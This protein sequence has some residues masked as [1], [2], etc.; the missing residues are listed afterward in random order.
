[1]NRRFDIVVIGG[2]IVGLAT[3]RALQDGL[4][5]AGI[6]VLE[7]EAAVGSHQTG[8]NSG[9]IHS[10]LYYRPGSLKA[11]LCVRGRE[12]MLD[13]CRDAGIPFRVP[14]KLVV[15][16]REREIPILD[17]LQMNGIA[18]GLEI[19]RLGP[20]GIVEHE[21]HAVGVAALRVA[22]TGVVDFG[23]VARHLAGDLVGAGAEILTGWQ[24]DRIQIGDGGATVGS[25]EG[26]V[27]GRVVVNAAGLHA[28]RVARLSGEEPPV[29]IVPF[30]GEY[31]LLSAEASGLVGGLIYP[32]P[33]PRF[34]F[35]GVHF[36]RGIDDSV[37]VGPNAVLAL[38]REH[39]R[40]TRAQLSGLTEALGFRGFR[41]LARRHAVS[42]LAEMV[43]SKSRVLYA[44]EARRLVPALRSTD[45]RV[46]GSGVRAQAVYPDGALADDFVIAGDGPMLHEL[47][48]PSP[49]ATAAL[50]IG[51][52]LAQMVRD[53][54]GR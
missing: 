54:L 9:V 12:Q 51:D 49:A 39:Y 5:G 40:G 11:Q 38:G 25:G 30:R 6:V 32:V 48:A 52:H 22:A 33:D 19:E 1:M 53:R 35:L 45:L 13:Y 14:G 18:N 4:P 16:T 41:R 37:E 36:T 46:G 24:V 17:D 28:D 50:A 31:H 7:K 21:P 10:G 8:H 42:G 34:P 29:R 23:E 43:R 15:A 26:A 2:G 3:A 47:S 44:R 20:E 27:E